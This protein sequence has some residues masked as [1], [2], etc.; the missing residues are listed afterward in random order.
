MEDDKKTK[1]KKAK[2]SKEVKKMPFADLGW[3]RELVI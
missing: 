3:S 1:E 2:Q